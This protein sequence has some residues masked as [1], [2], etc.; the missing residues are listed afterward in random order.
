MTGQRGHDDLRGIH[1][2]YRLAAHP[3]L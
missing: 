3:R 2:P 1:L